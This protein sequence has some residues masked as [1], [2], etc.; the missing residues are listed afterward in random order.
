MSNTAIFQ[1]LFEKRIEEL[2][3]KVEKLG[4]EL[5]DVVDKRN[6]LFREIT[7]IEG[8]ISEKE[9]FVK[10]LTGQIEDEATENEERTGFKALRTN[11]NKQLKK[12]RVTLGKKKGKAQKLEEKHNA[13]V[14]DRLQAEGGLEDQER[15]LANLAELLKTKEKEKAKKSSGAS[16]EKPSTPNASESVTPSEK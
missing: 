15:N 12:E 13:L 16:S 9:S 7:L 6:A 2:E 4:G 3:E 1:Q 14:N 10:D 11:L 8:A 5:T